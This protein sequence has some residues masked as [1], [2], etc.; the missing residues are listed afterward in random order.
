MPQLKLK[1][2][3]AIDLEPHKDASSLIIPKAAKAHMIEGK[4]IEEFILNHKDPFDFCCRAKV[5]S[6]NKL[7]MRW[8]LVNVEI[9]MQK[10]TRYFISKKGGSLI[11]IAPSKEMP[12]EYK[13]A[14]KLSDDYFANIIDEIGYGIWDE[15]IHTKNKSVYEDTVET[16]IN[17][18]EL[19]TECNNMERFNWD[20]LDYQYYINKTKDIIIV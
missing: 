8:K 4:N 1:G 7:V 2:R 20:N 12:G 17:S 14:N 6:S 10:I 19:V 16:G 5:P 3:Y 9:P 15:R 13:R 18:N 11:K